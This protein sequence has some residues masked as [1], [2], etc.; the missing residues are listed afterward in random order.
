MVS[1]SSLRVADVRDFFPWDFLQKQPWCEANSLIFQRG[2]LSQTAFA[3]GLVL[4]AS[5]GNTIP[6]KE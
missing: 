1:T 4:P 3:R 5:D 6:G 2:K